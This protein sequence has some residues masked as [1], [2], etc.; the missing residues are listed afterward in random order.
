M[1]WLLVRP[2]DEDVVLPGEK[3]LYK[4]RRHWAAVT[5]ELFQFLAVLFLQG[6][7]AMRGTTGMG[8]VGV[9]WDFRNLFSMTP[10]ETNNKIPSR[11]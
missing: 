4:E 11:I 5:P 8:T 3:I 10:M 7:F 6:A 2:H 1:A 9:A